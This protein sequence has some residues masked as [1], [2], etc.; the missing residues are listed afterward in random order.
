MNTYRINYSIGGDEIESTELTERSETTARKMF[1]VFCK[2]GTITSI[3]LV[4]E[5]AQASKQQ[6]RDTLAAIMQMVEELGPDSYLK[7]AFAGC[8]EIAE[9]NIENDGADSLKE[10]LELAEEKIAQGE[11][12]RQQT[13]RDHEAAFNQNRQSEAENEALKAELSLAK[14]QLSGKDEL[15][16]NAI[17]ERDDAQ[18]SAQ[19]AEADRQLA[20]E[21]VT[22]LKARLYDY[23]T[24]GA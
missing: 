9:W 24:A 20:E 3:E 23:M 22:Q 21:T 15:I 10:R 17:I 7:T 16:K 1:K 14:N 2:S 6:E 19:E 13:K 11:A 12:E 18:G 5:N 8:F 4:R